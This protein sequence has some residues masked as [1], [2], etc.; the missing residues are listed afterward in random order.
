[1]RFASFSLYE[2]VETNVMKRFKTRLGDVESLETLALLSTIVPQTTA[3]VAPAHESAKG[4]HLHLNGTAQGQMTLGMTVDTGPTHNLHGQGSLGGSTFTVTG[5]V[6][7]TGLIVLK[8]RPVSGTLNLSNANGTITIALHSDSPQNG[9]SGLSN[10]INYVIT[11][12]TGK[13]AHA[14]DHGLAHVTFQTPVD[15]GSPG[16]FTITLHSAK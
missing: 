12:G 15:I 6:E 11:G 7:R 13:Y 1:M 16:G 5:D 2:H 8:H 3:E 14:V 9:P 4:S 10:Q